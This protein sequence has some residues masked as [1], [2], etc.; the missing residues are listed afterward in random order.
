MPWMRLY[1]LVGEGSVHD[2]GE[3]VIR[4]AGGFADGA[5]VVPG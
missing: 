3:G 5:G 4:N 2:S 1:M